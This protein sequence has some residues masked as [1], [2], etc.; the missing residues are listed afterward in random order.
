MLPENISDTDKQSEC[1]VLG[2]V[3][4]L[5]GDKWTVMIVGGLSD[6][7]KRFNEL[8]RLIGGIS[9]RMLTLTLRRLEEEGI[10]SRTV[11][12]TIPP[13]VDYELTPHGYTLIEP[14][15]S[16]SDWAIKHRSFRDSADSSE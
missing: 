15:K 12:P 11:F 1:R 5:I 16:L 13:R 3:L 6:G 7:P 4:S 2:D 8:R 10:V 14:L 9:Q